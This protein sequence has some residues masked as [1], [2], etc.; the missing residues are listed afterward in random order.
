MQEIPELGRKVVVLLAARLHPARLNL[1][2]AIQ[3]KKEL[4]FVS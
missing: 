2:V 3:E 1:V 4:V